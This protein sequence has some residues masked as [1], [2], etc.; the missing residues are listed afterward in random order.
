MEKKY[1]PEFNL[2]SSDVFLFKIELTSLLT[3]GQDHHKHTY[4]LLHMYAASET[5]RKVILKK[6]PSHLKTKTK[7]DHTLF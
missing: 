2:G 7:R 1:E 4:T 3:M 5:H 6:R